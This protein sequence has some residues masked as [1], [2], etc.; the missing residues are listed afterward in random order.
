MK[1]SW[2]VYCTVSL[3]TESFKDKN[4]RGADLGCMLLSN[5][6]KDDA[7]VELLT[8]YAPKSSISNSTLLI[9]Q[10]LDT[11]VKGAGNKYNE[12]ANF[13][14]LASCISDLSRVCS[15]LLDYV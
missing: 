12:N 5:L 3:L 11:F 8:I 2:F 13:D 9:T 4:V 14:F 7:A 1:R 10:L 6:T 15:R